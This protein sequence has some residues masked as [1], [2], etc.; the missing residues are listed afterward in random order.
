MFISSSLSIQE[1]SVAARRL[2][3]D[4]HRDSAD[5]LHNL[6]KRNWAVQF[7]CTSLLRQ[8][9]EVQTRMVQKHVGERTYLSWYRY[10]FSRPMPHYNVRHMGRNLVSLTRLALCVSSGHKWCQT[11]DSC[12]FCWQAL[13]CYLE[14]QSSIKTF[15]KRSVELEYSETHS[16][17]C[18][19]VLHHL[20][21]S[22]NR[23]V[24]HRSCAGGRS[25]GS[26]WWHVREPDCGK[27]SLHA[28]GWHC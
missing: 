24:F 3:N 18:G 11:R 25:S 22:D 1:V 14:C 23:C 20:T 28:F 9:N 16:E 26:F 2:S 13:H 21:Q 5:Y 7:V 27:V 4:V 6:H 10:S 19:E 12:W 15:E 8:G 17:T